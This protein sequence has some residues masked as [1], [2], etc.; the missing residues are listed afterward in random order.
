[1]THAPETSNNDGH[2][3]AFM[4]GLAAY[5]MWGIFPLYFKVIEAAGAIEILSHRI[6]WSVPFAF[7]LILAR[8]QMS[9]LIRAIKTP[10]VLGLLALS[11]S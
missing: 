5:I 11:S 10:K 1:M 3:S 9:D 8:R 2:R 6:I 7:L 4:A